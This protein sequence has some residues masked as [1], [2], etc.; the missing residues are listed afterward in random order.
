MEG[1]RRKIF[2]LATAL[3]IS[4]AGTQSVSAQERDHL[5]GDWAGSRSWLAERGIIF[6]VQATQFYQGVVD[7]S[8]DN[9]WQYGV[10]GDY[11]LT[12]LG[13]RA[14]LWKGLILNLHAETRAGDVD[15]QTSGTIRRC[16][17]DLCTVE[18]RL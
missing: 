18:R 4:A 11:F 12:V 10:K 16:G 17:G 15:E 2:G 8:P 1:T 13:E 7:G 9:D 3:L 5:L 6:D 14:G